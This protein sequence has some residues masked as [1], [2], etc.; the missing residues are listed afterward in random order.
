MNRASFT[1]EAT[2]YE[3]G[4]HYRTRGHGI[5]LSRQRISVIYPARMD[6]TVEIFGC[7]PGFLQLGEGENTVCIPDP[8]WGGGGGPGTPGVPSDG[9]PSGHGASGGSPPKPPKSAD[10][11]HVIAVGKTW[12]KQC[13][14]TATTD[15]DISA[16]C[17]KKQSTCVA[18]YPNRQ[19]LCTEYMEHCMMGV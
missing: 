13:K 15:A 11:R 17:G 7:A 18:Q 6:E 14:K 9:D 8:S 10:K 2:L 5:D 3:S 1:A 12:R 16:C 19:T 4:T